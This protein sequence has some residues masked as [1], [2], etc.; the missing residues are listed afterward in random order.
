ME[1]HVWSVSQRS[2]DVMK[3][4]TIM[5]SIFIPLTFL[6]GLYGMN[7]DYLPELHYRRAYHTL[8][9]IMGLVALGMLLWFRWLGWLG[10]ED[11]GAEEED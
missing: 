7:F 11:D 5:A 3:V 2:N 1:M 10:R 9:A 6:A 8:L 4:L